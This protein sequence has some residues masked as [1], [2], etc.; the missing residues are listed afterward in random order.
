[1]PDIATARLDE[2]PTIMALERGD[3]Y[4]HVVGRWSAEQH[5][6]EMALPGSLYLVTRD[7]SGVPQGFVMLQRLDDPDRCAHLRR[8]AVARPGEGAGAALLGAGLAHVFGATA[9]HRLQLVVF[10][11]NER[12]RRAYARAGLVEEGLL[13]DIKRSPDGRFRSMLMM[14]ILRPEWEASNEVLSAGA[15]QKVA[16]EGWRPMPF[17]PITQG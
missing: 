14:S 17:A 8:I 5:A 15:R 16:E 12:A 4:E 10:P 2:V 11:E 9:A 6:A 3:G 7:A 1:M 13:R